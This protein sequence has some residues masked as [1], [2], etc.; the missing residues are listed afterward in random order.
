MVFN[1]QLLTIYVK[2]S[3][4][5]CSLVWYLIEIS[6]DVIEKIITGMLNEPV[7]YNYEKWG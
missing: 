2:V 1:F 3:C 7:G 5:T 6:R 4:V